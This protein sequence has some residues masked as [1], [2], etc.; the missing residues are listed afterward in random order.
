MADQYP[1]SDFIVDLDDRNVIH[2]PSKILFSFY[3]YSNEDDW[4]SSESV[5]YRDN[6]DFQGDRM[7]LAAAAKKAAIVAGMKA[8]KP[9]LQ[10][11]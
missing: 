11:S 8:R 10:R 7:E 6:P 2:K 5:V 3:E 9:A 4:R 1:V